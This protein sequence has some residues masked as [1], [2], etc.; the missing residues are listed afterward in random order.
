MV[1]ALLRLPRGA[2]P[3]NPNPDPHG[4][5]RAADQRGVAGAGAPAA[6]GAGGAG[7][8]VAAPR[9]APAAAVRRHLV[10]RALPPRR[11]KLPHAAVGGEG[12]ASARSGACPR[13]AARG[14]S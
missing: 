12:C 14:A 4:P 10:S 3:H 11:L 13:A 8:P 7:V 6:A 1:L 5:Q 2:D 9:R